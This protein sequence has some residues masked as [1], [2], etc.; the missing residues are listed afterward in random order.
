MDGGGVWLGPI[1]CLT[2]DGDARAAALY[3]RHYSCYE[4]RDGRRDRPGYRQRNLVLGPGEKMVLITAD[5]DAVFGWRR[6]VNR[7]G[8]TGV[9]AAVFRN[10]G[11]CLSSALVRAAEVWAWLRWGATRVYTYVN[12]GAVRSVNP[13]YCFKAAGWRCVGHTKKRGLVVLAKGPRGFPG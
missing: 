13:G 8:Q 5:G 11:P 3:R 6:F 7:D 12:A 2:R 10:E 9:N 4:H 1:W